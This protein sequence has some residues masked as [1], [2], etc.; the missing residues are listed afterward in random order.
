MSGGV[1]SSVSAML[2]LEQGFEIIGVTFRFW[3]KSG[4]DHHDADDARALAGKLGIRHIHFDAREEFRD[5]IIGYFKDEYLA[6]RT[7]FPCAKCNPQL[8]WKLLF[9]IAES[10]NAEF[11]STGH[12]VR[13]VEKDGK[14]YLTNGTD[15]DKDQ[16]FFL[17]GLDP[18]QLNRIIF[19]L[20]HLTKPDVRNIA[21]KHGFE[22]ISVKKDSLGVCFAAADG[23]YRPLLDALMSDQE[24]AGVIPGDFIDMEGN[25]LGK[26]AGIPYYT[27]GQRRGLGL[28]LNQAVFVRNILPETNQV[29]LSQLKEMYKTEFLVKDW[30]IHYPEDLD[31]ELVV[32]VRYRK[33][34]TISRLERQS[35]GLLKVLLSEPVE[36]IAPGQT[37][38]FYK[39]GL[40]AGGGFI[41]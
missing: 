32:K 12:Y 5:Q 30:K 38:V 7:P 37:A 19:P 39:A 29:V 18:W 20:G 16:S 27:V 15:P 11:V 36:S 8:K 41:L 31:S 13:K 4:E 3:D 34:E 28:N 14:V 23:N 25:V 9:D 6:G 40:L 21:L 1:D 17:W 2:L 33:Q 26:H 10:E 35:D 22:R 24:K